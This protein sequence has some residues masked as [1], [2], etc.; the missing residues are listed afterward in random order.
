M[1]ILA[2]GDV[3]RKEGTDFLEKILKEFKEDKNIDV[4][5]ANGENSAEGNGITPQS[6]KSLFRIGVDIIT[7]GNHVFKRREI[8]PFLNESKN[9]VRPAN[10]PS[11]TTPGV[12]FCKYTSNGVKIGVVNMLGTVFME[13]LRCPFETIDSILEQIKDCKIKIVDFH[14]EATSEKRSLGFYLDGRVSAIFGTHTHVQ[15][16][17]EEIL[18]KG[19]GYISDI[20]MTGVINS[21][22]GVKTEQVVK[23]LKEK[24]PVRFENAT[25]SCKME[26]AVFDIDE[27]TGKTKSVERFRIT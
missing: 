23:K 26:C 8:K 16:S 24:L 18:P 22:L 1:R 6:A 10:Y 21:V 17:D 9:I 27:N 5:I 15:T 2:V 20:G 14:A 25:G 4:V 7:N 11:K 3:V 12:G 13:S 19:T